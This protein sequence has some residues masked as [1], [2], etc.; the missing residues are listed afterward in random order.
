MGTFVNLRQQFLPM[1]WRYSF[2]RSVNEFNQY[3]RLNTWSHHLYRINNKQHN[4][5]QWMCGALSSLSESNGV[6]AVYTRSDLHI[7]EYD[8][9]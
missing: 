4:I 3:G 7:D 1:E 6:D 8:E 2:N 9:N 5:Q